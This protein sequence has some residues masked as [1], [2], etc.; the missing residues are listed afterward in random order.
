M[1]EPATGPAAAPITFVGGKG[2][3]GKTTLAA[4]HALALADA[5]HRVLVVSTDPA[6]S[7]GDALEAPLK[8]E[9]VQV[10]PNLW[11][12][13]PDA[14][15]AVRR[16][17][18]Q[19]AEDARKAVPR[20]VLP[21]V[22]RHLEQAGASPGMAESALADLLVDRMEEVGRRWD[23]LV[24]DSAPTGH[25]LRLLNLP[26]LLTPWIVGLTRQRER[27]R[28]AEAFADVVGDSA[29]EDDPLTER[30]HARRHRLER[31]AERL[32]RDAVV[33]LVTLPRRMVLAETAR[34]VEQLT[35]AGF[36]L[37][38]VVVNQIPP[39]AAAGP[40]TAEALAATR[41]R[42]A[43]LGTVEVPLQDAEPTGPDRLRSL[44]ALLVPR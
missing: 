36:R 7:L 1:T 4:A 28:R 44:A 38:P 39:E 34:A 19:V 43:A 35:G 16:R 31:A 26:T 42:F 14:D 11:A 5:G 33:R 24:V 32:R 23:A 15:A 29:E 22:R 8:D 21:A 2:G 30:L 40:D 12:A 18:A 25:L 13:E 20:E 17:I 27:A 3:V 10:A 9:P 41:E 6:H 37:A